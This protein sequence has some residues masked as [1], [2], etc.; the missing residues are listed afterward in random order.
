MRDNGV[1]ELPIEEEAGAGAGP[2]Q[3]DGG[4]R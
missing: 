1:E 2:G 3:E 4:G